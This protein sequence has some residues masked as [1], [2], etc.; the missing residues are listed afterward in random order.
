[1]NSWKGEFLMTNTKKK[2]G[3]KRKLLGAIG[4]LSISAA[5]LVSSTFAWFSLNRTVT[6]QT[7]TVQAK[8]A[9]PFLKISANGTN[10]YKA[11]DATADTS[12]DTGAWAIQ[13]TAVINE[14]SAAAA[15]LKLIAPKTI[16]ATPTWVWNQSSDPTNPNTQNV[17]SGTG[18]QNVTLSIDTTNNQNSDRSAIMTGTVGTGTFEDAFVLKQTLSFQN[19]SKDSAGTNLKIDSVSFS[20][21][22][23]STST[24]DQAVRILVVNSEGKFALYK[25][26]GTLVKNAT[27]FALEAENGAT[28]TPMTTTAASAA[29]VPIIAASLAAEATTSIDIYMYFDGN[30]AQAYTNNAF[31]LTGVNASFQ[32]SID[33]ESTANP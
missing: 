6:A 11:L 1:M 16:G 5:M 2:H 23:T 31:D 21:A 10:F 27:T 12:T 26:D 14:Q 15:R 20:R 28:G 19:I 25:G 7:M 13:T 9:D 3:N 30:A 8:S 32:F 24:F 29:G 4:M 17:A 18:N 22:D 33:S